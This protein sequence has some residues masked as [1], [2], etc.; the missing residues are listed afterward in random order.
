MFQRFLKD[1]STTTYINYVAARN[2]TKSSVKNA[3]VNFEKDVINNAKNRNVKPFWKYVNTKLKRKPGISSLRKE[4]G[5]ITVN[6][7]EKADALN[8]YFS[9]VF[10]NEDI[11]HM[12]VLGDKS[13]NNTLNELDISVNV[14]M[15][16]LAKLDSSK[17]MGPD[18]GE[19]ILRVM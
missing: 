17:S 13:N 18:L 4:N 9:S 10:V 19:L 5:D 1:R 16:K 15:N 2:A 6:D 12:P 8:D 14:I 7:Q 11:S 3:V